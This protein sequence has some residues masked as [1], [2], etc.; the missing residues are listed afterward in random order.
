MRSCH[1]PELCVYF[2]PKKSKIVFS[3][4]IEIPLLWYVGNNLTHLTTEVIINNNKIYHFTTHLQLGPINLRSCHSPELCVYFEPKQSEIVFS[5]YIEIPLIWYVG[6]NL[7]HLRTDVVI[8]NNK[9]Y[10]FNTHVQ[11]GP[12]NLRSCHSPELCVYFEPKQSKIVFSIYIEIPFLWY[13]GHSL[14]HLRTDVMKIINNILTILLHMF[15][16]AQ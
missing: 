11:S 3:I 9:I 14:T 2:E 7:T 1:S 4:Y 6:N 15:N 16:Q 12:I 13:I 10:H 5:I 8:N